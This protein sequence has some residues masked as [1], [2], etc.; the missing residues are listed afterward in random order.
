MN[1][2]ARFIPFAILGGLSCVDFHRTPEQIRTALQGRQV[3]EKIVH[4][5]EY[6]IH[7]IAIGEPGDPPVLFIH[8]SPGSWDNYLDVIPSR[9]LDQSLLIFYDRPGFGKSM[10]LN[11]MP[12]IR[13]QAKA[14]LSVLQ[15]YTDKPAIVVGHS[16]G[17][18]VALQLAL[19][20][21]DA[22]KASVL[23]GAS[24][25]PDLE[26]LR[27]YNYAGDFLSF[28][29]PGEMVRSNQEMFPMKTE[30]TEQKK[31]ILA[32]DAQ[33]SRGPALYVLHGTSDGLVPVENAN[34]LY[35]YVGPISSLTC[36]ELL[37]GEGHLI[38]WEHPDLLARM[39]GWARDGSCPQENAYNPAKRL[40][41]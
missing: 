38:P 41:N 31:Q 18:P 11:A 29:I 34:F 12:D 4:S 9:P 17:G 2:V 22:V 32:D 6:A 27:W 20:H 1:A 16:Y 10:P 21:P 3:Q 37:P 5:E 33:G 39:I 24:V 23:L 28:M 26:E 14:A 8:G 15:A 7:T 19:D 40:A 35:S 36:I 30:L 13:K 25:D